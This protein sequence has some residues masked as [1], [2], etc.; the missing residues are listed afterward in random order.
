MP[1]ASDLYLP[2]VAEPEKKTLVPVP[3]S[4]TPCLLTEAEWVQAWQSA[5]FEMSVEE[6]ERA[7]YRVFPSPYL[8]PAP[9]TIQ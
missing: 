3:Y 6:F 8:H 9:E 1:L 2:A 5:F 4:N 7:W